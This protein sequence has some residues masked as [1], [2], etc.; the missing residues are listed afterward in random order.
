MDR[1]VHLVSGGQATT[2]PRTDA[3]L[4]AALDAG[5]ASAL[6]T[7]YDRH[8]GLVYGVGL[9]ILKSAEEAEDLTQEVFLA[10]SAEHSYDPARGQLAGLLVA[11]TRSRAIDRLRSRGRRL[12]LLRSWHR[13]APAVTLP[14]TPP[15]QV[16]T[17]ECAERVRAAL[18][19]LSDRE[20]EVLELAY[21]GGLTQVEI[22]DRLG[23][24]LGSVK[25]WARRGLLN[26]KDSLRDLVG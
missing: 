24:P 6:G 21:F 2:P 7:L 23:A 26:L 8:A 4:L 12:R 15:Q 16:S 17:K 14:A 5:D 25:S 20:R 11:M 9:A 1:G 18:A 22:A 13:S 3:D 10:L 19:E